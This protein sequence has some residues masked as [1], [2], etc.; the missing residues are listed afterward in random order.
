L[1]NRRR[2]GDLTF[3]ICTRGPAVFGAEADPFPMFLPRGVQTWAAILGRPFH[4]SG[5]N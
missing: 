3:E 5:K 4:F 2:D 1:T